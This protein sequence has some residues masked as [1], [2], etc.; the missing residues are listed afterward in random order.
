MVVDV[1]DVAD[2]VVGGFDVMHGWEGHK[3]VID[4]A[5]ATVCICVGGGIV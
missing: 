4:A 2:V 5:G 3:G 1:V